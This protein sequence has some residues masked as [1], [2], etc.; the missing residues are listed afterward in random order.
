MNRAEHS[1]PVILPSQSPRDFAPALRK[2]TFI[3]RE[4]G[5]QPLLYRTRKTEIDLL[6]RQGALQAAEDLVS[7][8][9][10]EW[11]PRARG[12]GSLCFGVK[13]QR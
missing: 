12:R 4:W 9:L 13:R 3:A 5:N 11:E 1:P 8:A 2:G 7:V 10:R 6:I